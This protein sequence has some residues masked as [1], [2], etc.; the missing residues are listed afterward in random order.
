M[1]KTIESAPKTG[2]ILGYDPCLKRPFIMWF[3]YPKNGFEVQGS[4]FNDETPTHWM[5]LP[6]IP[7]KGALCT[8]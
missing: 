7:K 6:A 4:A 3:N 8:S 5:E 2:A 1:W